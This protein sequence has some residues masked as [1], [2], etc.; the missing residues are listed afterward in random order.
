MLIGLTGTNPERV[1]AVAE[2]LARLHS[3][4]RIGFTRP[5]RMLVAEALGVSTDDLE[6]IRQNPR[7]ELGNSPPAAL[8]V[9]LLSGAEETCGFEVWERLLAARLARYRFTGGPAVRLVVDDVA[10][11]MQAQAIRNHGGI[12]CGIYER[13]DRGIAPELLNIAFRGRGEPAW[14]AAE[15][16]G[17]AAIKN[18]TVSRGEAIA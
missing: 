2:T 11:S 9:G 17:S 14:I 8:I 13:G 3:F 4:S 7:P 5:V 15:L 18:R 12:V 16:M 10:T 1:A 6:R